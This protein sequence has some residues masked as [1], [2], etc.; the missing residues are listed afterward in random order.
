M[1]T[2]IQ[3]PIFSKVTV[4]ILFICN[5]YTSI[6]FSNPLPQFSFPVD[7]SNDGNTTTQT[8]LFSNPFPQLLFEPIKDV[9]FPVES[10]DVKPTTQR[11]QEPT[12]DTNFPV[13]SNNVKSTT[14]ASD[15]ILIPRILDFNDVK[16]CIDDDYSMPFVNSTGEVTIQIHVVGLIYIYL[17]L[18]VIN[19][20][21]N[22]SSLC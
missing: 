14:E 12:Q 20:W 7:T 22:I 2:Y 17:I 1:A 15:E 5:L 13:K 3:F 6:V 18:I 21:Y 16:N 10:N 8:D 11:S 9:A 19:Q 4:T